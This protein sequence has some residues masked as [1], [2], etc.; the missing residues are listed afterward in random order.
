MELLDDFGEYL[1]HLCARSPDR[2]QKMTWRDG[3]NAALTCR[4]ACPCFGG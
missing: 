2:D 1:E 3:T 4:F